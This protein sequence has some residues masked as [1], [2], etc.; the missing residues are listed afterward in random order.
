MLQD[1]LFSP[2]LL[3]LSFAF[4]AL[5]MDSL[6]HAQSPVGAIANSQTETSTQPDKDGSDLATAT[7]PVVKVLSSFD[8]AYGAAYKDHPD[9]AG[10]VGPNDVVDFVGAYFIVRQKSTGKILRQQTQKQF[11]S[12]LGVNPGTLNDPRIVY[13]PVSNRWYAVSAGPYMFLAASRDSDPLHPWQ[14]VVVS[15]IISGDLLPRIGVDVNGLYICGYGGMVNKVNTADCFVFPKADVLWT[16]VQKLSLARM[17]TFTKLPY[18]LFP[19]TDWNPGKGPADPEMF[20]TR[21]GG[22]NVSSPIPMVL[23]ANKITWSGAVPTMSA[24]Q[25]VLTAMTYDTPGPALQPSGPPIRGA[26]NHRFFNL[27]GVG[28]SVFAATGSKM[29]GRSGIKWFEVN[30]SGALLQQGAITDPN[31][32]VLFPTVAVD[33]NRN[34]AIGYTKVSASEAASV[35]VSA[36]LGTDPA[37]TL[38]A[39]VLVAPGTTTYKCSTNPVGWG[40]YSSTV[41]DPTNP[42]VLWTFQEY[43]HSSTAC[44]WTTRWVSFSL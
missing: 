9:T 29:N 16:S 12:A 6:A 39:P 26:E 21:Q 30:S 3:S 27:F 18:E 25:T 17:K 28:T 37:G 36:R 20:L 8:G 1:N 7:G 43:A 33:K 41:V 35:Y 14:A 22:Q 44:Q 31:Y 4:L 23:L 2:R 34:L 5:F 11:W 42:L 15:K 32:D 40:T 38:R 24:S 19:A 13:D 10:A